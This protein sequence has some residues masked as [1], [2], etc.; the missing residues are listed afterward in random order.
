MLSKIKSSNEIV[1]KI[2][3][4]DIIN[5]DEMSKVLEESLRTIATSDIFNIVE[6]RITRRIIELNK[7]LQK[8][9]KKSTEAV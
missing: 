6:Q 1:K 8:K 4:P 2:N 3:T 7:K 9:I 5:T